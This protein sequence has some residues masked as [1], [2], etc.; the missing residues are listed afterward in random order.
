[1]NAVTEP[2][3]G[4]TTGGAD[5]PAVLSD[6]MLPPLPGT[7]GE[8]NTIARYFDG[9]NVRLGDDA[10]AAFLKHAALQ[11]Y[12]VIH[13]AAHAIVDEVDNASTALVLSPTAD[14]SGFVSPGDLARLHLDAEMVVLSACRSARGVLIGG[15]G[16]QGLTTP[17]LE[18]G[19]RSVVASRWKVDDQR[20]ATFVVDFYTQLA[21]GLAVSDALRAAKLAAIARGARPAEWAAFTVVGDPLVT[22]PLQLPV[23]AWRS[24][25][26]IFMIAGILV[27][28]A[29]LAIT[30]TTVR[31]YRI[32]RNPN[33]AERTVLPATGADTH[34]E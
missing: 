4:A 15:E 23:P 30:T 25:T 29:L 32:S 18:A 3:T 26:S 34:H 9:A 17:L 20:T 21:R 27:C 5:R 33:R 6:T 24:R 8:V 28:A 14:E 7:R 16:V 19:A 12:S 1:M 31:R 10:S 11:K 13:F 22:L 2:R